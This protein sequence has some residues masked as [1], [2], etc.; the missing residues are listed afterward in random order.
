M[1]VIHRAGIVLVLA[2]LVAG[3]GGVPK[4]VETR[5]EVRP[6]VKIDHGPPGAIV[7]VDGLTIGKL[8]TTADVFFIKEGAQ[9][10]VIYNAGRPVYDRQIFI[11][12]NTRKMID[13]ADK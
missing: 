13:L 11:K 6:S 12:N 1:T 8:T 4:H 2:C 7:T 3:C 5:A 10:L 9:R